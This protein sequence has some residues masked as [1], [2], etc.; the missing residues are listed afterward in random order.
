MNRCVLSV[1]RYLI[2]AFVTACWATA[3]LAQGGPTITGQV[4]VKN[5]ATSPVI[6]SSIDN[7]A[8]IPYATGAFSGA[9]PCDRECRIDFPAVPAGHRLVIQNITGFVSYTSTPLSVLVQAAPKFPGPGC[10]SFFLVPSA[11]GN[12]GA[13]TA[14]YQPVLMYL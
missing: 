14:F 9:S 1:S 6:T 13:F 7:P 5:P 4:T 2:P 11:L 10:C 3:S 12:Q 8:R